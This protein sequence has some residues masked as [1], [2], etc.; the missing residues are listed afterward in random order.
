MNLNLMLQGKKE[1]FMI[2][3]VRKSWKGKS[4]MQQEAERIPYFAE[5]EPAIENHWQRA[6]SGAD[7]TDTI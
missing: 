3:L 7:F 1:D 4:M 5:G 6:V 2:H